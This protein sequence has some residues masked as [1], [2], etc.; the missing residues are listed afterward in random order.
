M[1][2]LRGPLGGLLA[3]AVL[4]WLGMAVST[5]SL[6]HRVGV[7][8]VRAYGTCLLAWPLVARRVRQ[9]QREHPTSR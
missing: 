8:A 3:L 2:L 7:P 6:L 4:V 1:S 5:A 9:L